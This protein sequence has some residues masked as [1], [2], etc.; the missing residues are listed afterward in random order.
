VKVG[1]ADELGVGV[2]V[3]RTGVA[4]LDVAERNDRGYCAGVDEYLTACIAV[5]D[6][7][8]QCD[9]AAAVVVDAAAAAVGATICRVS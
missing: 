4:A 9:R 2:D 7:I 1:C 3:S 6:V 8:G 5:N